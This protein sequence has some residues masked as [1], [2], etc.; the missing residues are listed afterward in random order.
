MKLLFDQNISFRVLKKIKDVYPNA[1]Q[2]RDLHLENSSDK[3]IWFYAKKHNYTIVTFDIDFSNLTT[4]Y[5]FPPKIIW[6][7]V[8][9]TT[10]K[11]LALLFQDKYGIIHSFCKESSI[12]CLEINE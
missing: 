7:R 1:K 4:L 9:N 2:V 11:K 5:G 8:G 12:G 3:D 10:T 6:I